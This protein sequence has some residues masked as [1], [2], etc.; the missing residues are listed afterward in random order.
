[1]SSA[2]TSA[3]VRARLSLFMVVQVVET[4]S[5]WILNQRLSSLHMELYPQLMRSI[6]ILEKEMS[7]AAFWSARVDKIRF[8]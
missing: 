7:S 1:M 4:P 3:P 6:K 8:P 5:I 2:W